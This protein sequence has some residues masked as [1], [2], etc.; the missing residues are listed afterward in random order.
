MLSNYFTSEPISEDVTIR[1]SG[2]SY[3]ENHRITLEN[4]RYLKLLHY[5]FDHEIQVGECIVN[6]EIAQDCI[7]IFTELFE[8]EY[9]IYSMYLI[10]DF[11]TGEGSSSDTASMNANNS[12][13]FCYRVI[14]NTTKLSNHALGYAIDINPLQNPY[15]T[16][17]DGMPVYYHDNAEE[18]ADRSIS[19]DHMI[20]HEDLCYQ[21][22]TEHGF[23]WGGDW[24][25][26]KDY[27]H[28]E[29]TN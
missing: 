12:S 15:I 16:Y 19:K 9:E 28:F 20:T 10:D 4:L 29:K 11:W 26:S 18:Y 8:A 2:K 3:T 23:T 14:A 6:E 7:E 25:N 24:K 13:A 5:N 17:K 27:Q 1:I 22:F 21:L